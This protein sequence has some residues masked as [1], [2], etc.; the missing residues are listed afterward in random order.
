M[1]AAIRIVALRAITL[2]NNQTTTHITRFRI[3]F[4]PISRQSHAGEMIGAR[5]ARSY[6]VDE[7]VDLLVSKVAA[8][9]LRKRWHSCPGHSLRDHLPQSLIT[10]E[11]KIKRIIE[12]AR[13]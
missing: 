1:A 11:S 13:C 10:H 4:S 9:L 12:R 2:V 3:L 6:S 8:L 5:P 7:Y